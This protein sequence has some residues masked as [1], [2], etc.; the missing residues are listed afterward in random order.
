M[1]LHLDLVWIEFGLLSFYLYT[2]NLEDCYV[3]RSA[4]TVAFKTNTELFWQRF[5]HY[6]VL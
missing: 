4:V 2:Y 3:T 5:V 1:T 6:I